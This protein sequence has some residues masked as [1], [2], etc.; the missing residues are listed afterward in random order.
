MDMKEQL[1]TRDQ[2]A[3]IFHV[4][5][6]TIDRWLR[7]GELHRADT[8]GGIVRIPASEIER[9]LLAVP[10]LNSSKPEA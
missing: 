8:P 6:R 9:R 3:E 10:M 7:T 4:G 2:T 5:V 1:Y